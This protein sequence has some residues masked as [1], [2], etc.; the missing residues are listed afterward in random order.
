[1]SLRRRRDACVAATSE[2]RCVYTGKVPASPTVLLVTFPSGILFAV[3]ILYVLFSLEYCSLMSARVIQIFGD[4]GG[5]CYVIV[6]FP[7]IPYINII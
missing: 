3:L 5:L 6:A 7:G 1:M 4:L 2:R